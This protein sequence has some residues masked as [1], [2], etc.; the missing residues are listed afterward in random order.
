MDVRQPALHR[1]P[2]E[3][4]RKIEGAVVRRVVDR[5]LQQTKLREQL[6]R[7]VPA[8]ALGPQERDLL[9]EVGAALLLRDAVGVVP[10]V[11]GAVHVHRALPV[12]ARAVVLL[13]EPVV[14]LRL[15]LLREVEVR[16]D[17][18]V[19]VVR[20]HQPDHLVVLPRL[21]V[22][23]D[24]QVGLLDRDVEA[25]GLPE[26]AL[27]L[28]LLRLVDA[29]VHHLL[30]LH[31]RQRELVRGLPAVRA[32]VHADRLHR[33]PAAHV[34][35]LRNV[36][37]ADRL[38]VRGNVAVV[39]LRRVRVL[40]L[41]N[42]HGL[43]PLA[44]LD[45]RLDRLDGAP[46][47]DVV[48]DRRVHLLL[49]HEVVAPLLLELHHFRGERSAR[50]VNS[51][52]VRVALAVALER[53]RVH[54]QLLK[55]LARALVQPGLQQRARNPLEEVRLAHKALVLGDHLRSARGK[56]GAH[57][58][59]DRSGV[60]LLALL[61]LAGLLLLARVQQPLH[62]VA[63]QV[64]Q[65]GVPLGLRNRDRVV[66]PVQLLVHLHRF[67]HAGVLEEDPLGH[68]ELLVKHGK[69]SAH[70]VVVASVPVALGRRLLRNTVHI[71]QVAR[72]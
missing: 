17:E 48:V 9:R 24:R 1:R 37:V 59:V 20:R 52:P 33:L 46:G 55:E 68:L 6:D 54:A 41:D 12:L 19:L 69:A 14:A 21:L 50:Q 71:A 10:H 11:V 58:E 5:L 23:V 57:V 31:A 8:E 4:K 30:R 42:L 70:E 51:P 47:L 36:K 60:I 49:P 35:A 62:V 26:L 13:R 44:R 22:H 16:L 53:A 63:A 40:H 25:L 66:P 27:R 39:L 72:A 18:Q 56:T 29:K 61:H 45:G 43:V 28:H 3:V 34:V 7:R 64:L 2:A 65:L 38:K 15:E 67:L 32:R